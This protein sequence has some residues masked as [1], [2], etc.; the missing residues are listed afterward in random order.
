ML[1]LVRDSSNLHEY[2]TYHFEVVNP[3]TAP[4]KTMLVIDF[5]LIAQC[6]L[7]VNLY[8]VEITSRAANIIAYLIWRGTGHGLNTADR[9]LKI[10]R[11]LS[12]FFY[13]YG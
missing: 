5:W 13:T 3:K 7:G 4:K 12:D 11:A 1:K 6:V 10:S 2:R 8:N 9:I